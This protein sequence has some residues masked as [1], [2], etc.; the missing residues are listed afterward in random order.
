[1]P[2]TTLAEGTCISINVKGSS[3]EERYQDT[4]LSCR[5]ALAQHL[6]ISVVFQHEKDNLVDKNALSVC[7]NCPDLNLSS[8]IIGYVGKENIQRVHSALLS[9]VSNV[10]LD[11]ITS[12]FSPPPN[13]KR[14]WQAVIVVTKCGKWLPKDNN[15]VYNQTLHLG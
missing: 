15:Y 7:V 6:P 10:I 14:I 12:Y 13:S 11:R 4:L 2:S 3:W 9:G 8:S 1:M 5:R